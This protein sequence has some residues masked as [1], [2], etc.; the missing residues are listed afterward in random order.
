MG[1]RHPLSGARARARP[2]QRST[3]YNEN[4][5]LATMRHAMRDTLRKPPYGMEEVVRKHFV[6]V[7]PMLERQLARWL[8]ECANERSRAG[9]EKAYVEIME[10][11]AQ[12][13]AVEAGG[14]GASGAKPAEDPM[15]VS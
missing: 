3:E 4:I 14:E 7:K 8:D 2:G 10:L 12:A 1:V 9:M 11:I 15:E 5:R 6:T 13:E